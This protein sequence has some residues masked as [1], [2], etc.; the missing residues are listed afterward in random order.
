[1][2]EDKQLPRLPQGTKQ[3]PYCA[4]IILDAAIKCRYCGEFLN[5]PLKDSPDGKSAKSD[6]KQTGPLF[7]ASPSLWIL[8]PSF[9]KT[10]IVIAIC[11]FVAFWPVNNY[12]MKL[13]LNPKA[14]PLIEKYRVIVG[15][16][17]MAAA[18]L[19]LIGSAC[20]F[21]CRWLLPA[22]VL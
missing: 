20:T 2:P 6:E 11:Y 17:L 21:A 14:I 1:M 9:L 16:S 12:L 18:V 8:T 4:E 3:C 10:A 22:A 5:K 7:E 19:V 15:L 13:N